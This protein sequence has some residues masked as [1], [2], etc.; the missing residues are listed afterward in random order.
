M[1]EI[2]IKFKELTAN[3][4]KMQA[5][6]HVVL[7]I[8]NDETLVKGIK[9]YNKLSEI[10]STVSDTNKLYLEDVFVGGANKLTVM[11]VKDDF[12]IDNAIQQLDNIKF[13]YVGALSE[14]ATNHE[15]IASYIKASEKKQKT[16]KGV[17]YKKEGQDCMH[18]INVINEK[19]TFNDTRGEVKGY[20]VIPYLLGV[21]A[22]MPLSR[23]ATNY[24]LSSLKTVENID[25]I[26]GKIK[27]GNLVLNYNGEKCTI[28]SGNNTLTTIDKDHS[29][30][31]KSILI[32]ETM[33][34]MKD[35][36]ETNFKLYIGGYKNSFETQM[37]I[38]SSLNAYLKELENLEVLD[39][40]YDNKIEID[41][42][43]MRIYWQSKGKT[44]IAELG[45]GELKK[46]TCGKNVYLKADVKILEVIENF[47]LTVFLTV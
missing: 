4:V 36:L 40:Q 6:G 22:G 35:D 9:I 45:D 42:D 32:V 14:E 11:N 17:L 16:V 2:N 26:Q 46:R 13:N 27:A 25:D 47:Y 23:S 31:M 1:P 43:A 24:N 19:I 39:K 12:T 3:P 20:N 28:L 38:I 8:F 41:V 37:L 34:L 21:L 10:G 29:E 33:D 7:L 44:E 15:K 30:A 5:K 18:L